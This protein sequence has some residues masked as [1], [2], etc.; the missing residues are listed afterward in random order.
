VATDWVEDERDLLSWHRELDRLKRRAR[1]RLFRTLALTVLATAAA[2]Y[3]AARRVPLAES[4]ILIRVTEGTVMREDSPTST[5]DLGQFLND[6]ALSSRNLSKLIEERGL[7]PFERARGEQ[8]ALEELRSNITLEVYRNQFIEARGFNDDVRTA[9]VSIRFRHS[10]P[11]VSF[12][13][14]SALAQLV[15]SSESRRRANSSRDVVGLMQVALDQTGTRMD[16]RETQ[17]ASR[18]MALADAKR[19]RNNEQQ[20]AIEIE[21]KRLEED[22]KDQ[23]K[24]LAT[25]RKNKARAD[26]RF[27]LDSSSMNMQYRIVDE[28]PPPP[29]DSGKPIR[30]AMVALASFLILLPLC[31]VGV[32]A[33]DSRLHDREDVQR[34]GFEVVGHV[35]RFGGSEVGSLRSRQDGGRRREPPPMT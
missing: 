5:R 26:L 23:V 7:Y 27:A 24:A 32:G 3:M 30:L 12:A 35:P 6:S 18:R 19:S 28:R 14:A 8:F 33:F 10:D 13:V 21:I 20:A 31:A 17:L 25:M 16:E 4:R 22:L 11:V 2:V 15:I 29:P 9:R 34:L 1:A